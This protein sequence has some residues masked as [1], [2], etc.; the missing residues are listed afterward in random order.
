M[1]SQAIIDDDD[2]R[3]TAADLQKLIR[4]NKAL[5]DAII[6]IKQLLH[7]ERHISNPEPLP[8]EPE[9]KFSTAHLHLASFIDRC[10]GCVIW[11]LDPEAH[12]ELETNSRG[13]TLKILYP[14]TMDNG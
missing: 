2:T 6:D 1:S 9:I 8:S 13:A 11:T 7:N 4:I 3:P 14:R 5:L 12:L 10:N